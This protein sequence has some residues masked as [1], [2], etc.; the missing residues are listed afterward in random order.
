M[1][2]TPTTTPV[3][4][5]LGTNLIIIHYTS[6]KQQHNLHKDEGDLIMILVEAASRFLHAVIGELENPVEK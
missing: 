1:I 5:V 2:D 3:A 4:R 6:G